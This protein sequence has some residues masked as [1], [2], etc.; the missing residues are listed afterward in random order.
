MSKE[1]EITVLW[2]STHYVTVDD[3][4]SIEDI[5]AGYWEDIHPKDLK[6]INPNEAELYSHS[7]KIVRVVW[8]DFYADDEIEGVDE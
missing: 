6:Y 5:E 4:A 2:Q 7:V 3:D 1:L 8:S